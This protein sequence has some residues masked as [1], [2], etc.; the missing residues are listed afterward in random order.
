MQGSL[1]MYVTRKQKE[2]Q[3]EP[4]QDNSRNFK[5]QWNSK[6]KAVPSKA[7]TKI[8]EHFHCKTRASSRLD[9]E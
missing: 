4:K 7:Q 5:F 6:G 2:T 8:W 9:Q 1:N 3:P